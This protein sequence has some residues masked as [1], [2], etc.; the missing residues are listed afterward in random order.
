[1]F[2]T[3]T[4]TIVVI[5]NFEFFCAKVS[6]PISSGFPAQSFK[7]AIPLSYLT[8]SRRAQQLLK[9][10]DENRSVKSEEK[11]ETEFHKILGSKKILIVTLETLNKELEFL[12][13][14]LMGWH[15]ER[16]LNDDNK[17]K[18]IVMT[19]ENK[20]INGEYDQETFEFNSDQIG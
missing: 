12:E 13:S 14:S 7:K 9:C 15:I 18:V 8:K 17:G 10:V 4:T 19:S 2:N 5:P 1:M 16:G 20:D 6:C 3:E 11:S